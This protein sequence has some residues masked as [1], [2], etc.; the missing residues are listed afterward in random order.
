MSYVRWEVK[1]QSLKVIRSL[2]FDGGLESLLN[3]GDWQDLV[4]EVQDISSYLEASF[5]Y[6]WCEANGMVDGRQ[7]KE[8]FGLIFLLMFSFFIWFVF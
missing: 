8:F 6:V 3:I 2:L 4:E 1:K 7:G 5:S